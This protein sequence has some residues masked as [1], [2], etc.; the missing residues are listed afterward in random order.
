MTINALQL[1]DKGTRGRSESCVRLYFNHKFD[2]GDAGCI[3]HSVYDWPQNQKS[4]ITHKWLPGCYSGVPGVHPPA[5]LRPA[6][7]ALLRRARVLPAACHPLT[8][9]AVAGAGEGR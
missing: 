3:P 7:T 2:R 6:S 1:K 4:A 9:L 8:C 5:A